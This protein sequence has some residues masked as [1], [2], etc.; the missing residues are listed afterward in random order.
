MNDYPGYTAEPPLYMRLRRRR[1][2]LRLRQL[3]V[4][5]ALDV[6][7]EAVTLWE[8][9]RRR[10]ELNKLPRLARVLREDPR[11]FCIKALQEYCPAFAQ[12]IFGPH[13]CDATDMGTAA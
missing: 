5:E 4:A 3:D 9:G 8:S 11:E 6:T 7:P 1:E 2:E 12:G 10:V 13:N